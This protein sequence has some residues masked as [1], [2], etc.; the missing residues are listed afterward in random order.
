ML[1]LFGRV[2]HFVVSDVQ[3]KMRILR[4][5]GQSEKKDSYQ[6]IQG[7]VE[8]EVTENLTENKNQPSGC[9]T[10]LRLHR[11][12]DFILR[13]MQGVK[14]GPNDAKMST[15][16]ANAYDQSLANFHPWLIRKGVQLALHTLPT[17]KKLLEQMEIH[18]EES[19]SQTLG[20]VITEGQKIYTLVQ[21][22]FT[23]K[24]LLS[25]PWSV[26]I[27]YFLSYL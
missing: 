7:M 23:K 5:Y 8:F 26:V 27:R 2:F 19:A 13:F 1:H 11:A 3:D 15:V 21:D 25:L 18:D 22:L 12:L 6:T 17:R 24:D 20:A 10:L 16:G 4:E 14:E 9:R